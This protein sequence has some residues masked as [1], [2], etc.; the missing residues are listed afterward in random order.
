MPAPE[1][2]DIPDPRRGGAGTLSGGHMD[3]RAGKSAAANGSRGSRPWPLALPPG[4]L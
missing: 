1:G 3:S 4:I 2:T